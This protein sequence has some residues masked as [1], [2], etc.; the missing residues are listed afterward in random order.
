MI[1]HPQPKNSSFQA[2]IAA[3]CITREDTSTETWAADHQ[4]TSQGR[5]TADQQDPQAKN[6][7]LLVDFVRPVVCSLIYHHPVYNIPCIPRD[8]GQLKHEVQTISLLV[9]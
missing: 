2:H 4:S 8:N 5:P 3:I 9:R 1:S 6:L 7:P